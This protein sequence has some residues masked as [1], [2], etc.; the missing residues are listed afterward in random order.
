MKHTRDTGRDEPVV[1]VRRSGATPI[2]L[3]GRG[4]DAA[5]RRT[6][7]SSVVKCRP[8]RRLVLGVPACFEASAMKTFS[9]QRAD[10]EKDAPS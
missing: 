8:V 7:F 9:L 4:I 10:R 1:P 3:E 2:F 5:Q 6:R